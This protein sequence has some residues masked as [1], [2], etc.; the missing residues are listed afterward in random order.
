[1]HGPET[2]PYSV[3]LEGW[4]VISEAGPLLHCKAEILYC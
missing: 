4:D 3:Q 2:V 1:M